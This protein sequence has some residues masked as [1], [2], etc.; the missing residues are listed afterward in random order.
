MGTVARMIVSDPWPRLD[1]YLAAQLDDVS[2]TRIQALIR[3]GKV[4]VD[5]NAHLKSRLELL[6]GEEIIVDIPDGQ[7]PGS[8]TPEPMDLD[9]LHDDD[10]I[11]VINKPAGLVTHPGAGVASGTLANG[12]AAH[13]ANL[14]PT[15]G[16]LRP[17]IVHRLDKDTSGLIVVAKS[18]AAHTHLARQFE[19]RTVAKTYQA[20]VWDRVD[21][22]GTIDEP[23]GR[24]QRNRLAFTV[25]PSGRPAVT[26]YSVLEA[27][28]YFTL[29]QI[30]PR[31]GRS[32]QIRVHLAHLGHPVFGDH[33]YGGVRLEVSVTPAARDLNRE[34]RQDILRQ[35]LHA[36]ALEF[37]HPGTGKTVSFAAPLPGDMQ[38]AVER[39]RKRSDAA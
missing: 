14:S 38:A 24:D 30:R 22:P 33:L 10:T 27:Y 18:D 2:R 23:I 21:G 31:T 4:Q 8:L 12:L 35:A 5:G 39:L 6:G 3:A 16:P 26:E 13:F 36:A 37:T 11:A 29:L 25:A 20:I 15:G 17:G 7:P 1:R 19:E 9:I 28:A 32:H 34:L